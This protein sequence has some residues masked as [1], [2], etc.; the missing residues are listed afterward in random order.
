MLLFQN[1]RF[2]QGKV[3]FLVPDGFYFEDDPDMTSEYGFCA[4][5]PGKDYLCCWRF[6]EDCLG[7]AEELRAWFAPDCGLVSLSEITAVEMNGLKGHFVLYKNR[8]H[9]YYEARFD[10]GEGAQLAFLAETLGDIRRI[11]ARPEFAAA[12]EGIKTVK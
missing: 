10:L 3:S 4:W 6:Y 12:L 7:T 1:G 2:Y 5:A 8:N 9:Q 11:A